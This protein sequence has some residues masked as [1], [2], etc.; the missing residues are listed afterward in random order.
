[1]VLIAKEHPSKNLKSERIIS[2]SK[3]SA[4]GTWANESGSK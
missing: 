1:M 3:K 4:F 2:G